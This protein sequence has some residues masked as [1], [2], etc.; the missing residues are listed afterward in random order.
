LKAAHRTIAA[1]AVLLLLAAVVGL[2]SL[3]AFRQIS[4][5]AASR[6]QSLEVLLRADAFLSALKDA[7]T[8]QRG[9]ALT[10]DEAFLEPYLAVRERIPGQLEE[11]R[12]RTLDKPSQAHLDAVGPLMT[13]K[14]EE[15]ARVVELRRQQDD[16]GVLS[17]VRGG[18][19]KRLMDAIRGEMGAFFQ[20]EK[21][22][23]DEHEATFQS[24]MRFMLATIVGA[25]LITLA[26]ALLFAYSVYRQTQ[27]RLKAR[28]QIETKRLLTIQEETNRVL[29]QA[30]EAL[31]KSEESLAVTLASIGDAMIATDTEAK[32]TRLN[33]VAERL[34]GWTLAD[35]T[36]RFVDEIF[37]IVNKDTRQPTTIPV[38]STLAKGTVHGLANHTVLIARDGTE[39]DIADSC[40]PILNRSGAVVGAVLIFRNVSA[41]YALQQAVVDGA[42]LTKTILHTVAEGVITL[43]ADE[44]TVTLL[45]P[46][47]EQMFGVVAADMVGKNLSLLIPELGQATLRGLPEYCAASSEALTSGRG[48]ELMGQRKDG[49]RFPME[50]SVSEMTLGGKRYF[51]SIAR[52]IT[53]KKQA[54]ADQ[55]KLDQRLRDQQ[56]Y[57]RS[58]IESNVDALVITDPNGIVS[59]ANKRMAVLTG[60]TR[61][62]L[63]GSPF[64][65]YFTDPDRAAACIADALSATQVTDYELTARD[66]DGKTTMVS[67]NASTIYDRNRL[68]Q[69]VFAAARDMTERQLNHQTLEHANV[70]L[71]LARSAAEKANLAKSD[72]LSSMSHELRS[73][74]NA[75]LGFAQLMESEMPSP[76]E[77]QKQSIGHILVAGWHLLN[78]INEI[79]DLA[80]I[81]A[82]KVSLST[83]PVA[84]DEVLGECQS[85]LESEAQKRGITMTIP[86]SEHLPY[87]SADRTRIKQVFINLLSNAIKYNK[88][89]GTVVVTCHPISQDRVRISVT[90]TGAGMSADNLAQLFQPFNRLGREMASVP[91]TGI[92]L[93]V[94]ERLVKLMGGTISVESNVGVGSVFSIDLL[95]IAA[96]KFGLESSAPGGEP[97]AEAIGSRDASV[98]TLLY[99]EDN[100]ANMKLVEQLVARRT[101]MRL[102]TA[103]NGVLGIELA[104]KFQPTMILMDINLPGI[105]GVEAMRLLR[106]DP[107]TAHIPVVALSAHA[108]SRDIQKGLELGFFRYLTKPI[109]INEFMDTLDAV[110]RTQAPDEAGI[111]RTPDSGA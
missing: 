15:L 61:D 13:A 53:L 32:V 56:F 79:L 45:N 14:L 1:L 34:T 11:L 22:T 19:G 83:E 46:A 80:V 39:C 57:T 35:A 9:Y 67:Y 18:K 16:A 47:A 77:S 48:R 82:G 97:R 103:V 4:A 64:K 30:N 74:L 63:I 99:V 38:M 85:M 62:E 106:Q 81:E 88:D 25:C 40:A 76:T 23:L 102:L 17:A 41:E 8:G 78:L 20:L 89:H 72:F 66:R 70:A 54:E 49:S 73:P 86:R 101:S 98:H 84:L 37:V 68:L 108:S 10:G 91:G 2:P 59:D 26:F 71:E 60:C 44:G 65:K 111:S 24:D 12:R 52:D 87:V 51:T 69:G 29:G 43:L 104:R 6:Q 95:V 33:P 27:Q 75:I 21:N 42:A 7:E 110:L 58:L 31:L 107:T 92:G 90:D 96:P 28:L 109:K 94:T 50:M 93:V 105:S 100:P 36:G 55:N 3:S 5:A